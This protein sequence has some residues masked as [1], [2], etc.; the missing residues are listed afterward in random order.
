[1][2]EQLNIFEQSINADGDSR[3]VDCFVRLRKL[4]PKVFHFSSSEHDEKVFKNEIYR[5]LKND[6]KFNGEWMSFNKL[7]WQITWLVND[8][9]RTSKYL[10]FNEYNQKLY[11]DRDFR[12]WAELIRDVIEK[13][14]E[15][16]AA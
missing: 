3:Q 6:C 12:E 5:W 11:V 13:H 15:K 14:L 8:E 9:G 1:M 16:Q 2:T 4:H 10:Y 7:L